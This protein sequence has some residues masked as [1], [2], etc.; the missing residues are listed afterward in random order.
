MATA[1]KSMTL[2]LA[3]AQAMELETLA[4]ID[5]IPVTEAVRQ[6]IDEHIERRRRDDDFRKRLD[7]FMESEREI[8]ERLAR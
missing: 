6:A 5:D 4:R 8:L 2:R 3:A 7:A 1:T